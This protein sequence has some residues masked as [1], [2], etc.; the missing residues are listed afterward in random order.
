MTIPEFTYLGF[1]V[2]L[3][4]MCGPLGEV[5]SFYPVIYR[6]HT[7]VSEFGCSWENQ[8]QAEFAAIERIN[9]IVK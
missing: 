5:Q 7:W 1:K 9:E 8:E 6:N 3:C 4:V 2:I